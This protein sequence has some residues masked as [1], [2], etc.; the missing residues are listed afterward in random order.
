MEEAKLLSGDEISIHSIQEIPSKR[1]ISFP[2]ML[3]VAII[4][5]RMEVHWVGT[6]HKTCVCTEFHI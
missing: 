1:W 3:K 4:E 2:G 5:K 6:K